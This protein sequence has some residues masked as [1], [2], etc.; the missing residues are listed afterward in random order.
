MHVSTPSYKKSIKKWFLN[1]WMDTMGGINAG[2]AE[3]KE[4]ALVS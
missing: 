2:T 3:V 4:G 1:N